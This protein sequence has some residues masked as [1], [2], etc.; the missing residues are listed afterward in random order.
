MNLKKLNWIATLVVVLTLMVPWTAFAWVGPQGA[1]YSPG[2]TVVINGGNDENGAPGYAVGQIV[3]VAVT[4]PHDPSYDYGLSTCDEPVVV[5]DAGT[6]SCTAVLWSDPE[7]AVGAY[8]YTATAFA[9]DGVT[10]LFSESGA[11]TDA[12]GDDT[13]IVVACSPTSVDVNSATTCT[14]TVTNIASGTPNGY[15]QG[16]VT[17]TFISGTG[18]FSGNPCTLAQIGTSTAQAAT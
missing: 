18:T 2:S 17:F 4:G 12:A 3:T 1:D 5:G 13:S 14:A 16:Q 6:W 9:N 8:T 10:V 11:F 15:P 7:L